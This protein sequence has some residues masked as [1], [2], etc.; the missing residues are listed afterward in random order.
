MI[1]SI[2]RLLKAIDVGSTA[3]HR[4]DLSSRQVQLASAALLI[5]VAT[6]DQCFD[7]T[8]FEKLQL[9]LT[10][11]FSLEQDEVTE[12]VKLA[13]QEAAEATSLYQFTQLINRHCDQQQKY[14]LVCNLWQMAYAD[15]IL[16]KYEEHIIRRITD[17][18]HVSHSDFIRAKRHVS[19]SVGIIKSPGSKSSDS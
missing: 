1:K 8:E 5:E 18:I 11:T 2:Q 17:L 9:L 19:A 16:D 15:G 10:K 3:D 12:L 4:M 14:Q 7:D 13:E 6:I